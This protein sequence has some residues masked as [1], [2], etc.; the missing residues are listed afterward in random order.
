[1]LAQIFS[2]LCHLWCVRCVPKRHARIN[3]GAQTK[4]CRKTNYV[5]IGKQPREYCGDRDPVD[6]VRKHIIPFLVETDARNRV[7]V[8]FTMLQVACNAEQKRTSCVETS[9][10]HA[11]LAACREPSTRNKRTPAL[12][13]KPETETSPECGRVGA[14]NEEG[15]VRAVTPFMSRDAPTATSLCRW[16]PSRRQIPPS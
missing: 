1:M 13:A 10:S 3:T 5:Q 15:S 4:H 14:A 11:G 9:T 8:K 7:Y 6:G 2:A 16:N 12:R